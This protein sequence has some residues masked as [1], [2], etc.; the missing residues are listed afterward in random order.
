MGTP[1]S[2]ALS[3]H[4]PLWI[5]TEMINWILSR[6][7]LTDSLHSSFILRPQSREDNGVNMIR[8]MEGGCRLGWLAP[9]AEVTKQWWMPPLCSQSAT[10]PAQLPENLHWPN[11]RCSIWVWH[12]T[13]LQ[14]WHCWLLIVILIVIE[15]QFSYNG[16]QTTLST[17]TP[18]CKRI[19]FSDLIKWRDRGW[20]G[21]ESRIADK[22]VWETQH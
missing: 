13:H 1:G 18:M 10:F 8:T 21:V 4:C 16:S 17:Q 14:S 7:E 22:F 9:L 15:L 11:N 19:V 2:V 12:P 6:P 3:S 5:N 20:E